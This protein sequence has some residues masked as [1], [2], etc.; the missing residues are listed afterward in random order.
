MIQ[1]KINTKALYDAYD[2]C[3]VAMMEQVNQLTDSQLNSIPFHGSW[4]AGQVMEH[5]T[6]SNTGIAKALN[7]EGMAVGRNADA[8]EP[9]LREMFLDFSVK[10]QSPDFILPV[11]A[12]YEPKQVEEDFQNSLSLLK[13]VGDHA[14]LEEAIKHPAFGEI[15]KL[16]LLCFVKFHLQRHLLQLKKI[17][18]AL[19]CS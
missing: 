3:A 2:E 1:E 15:T 10:F 17:V 19:R 13:K 7:I 16:E 11:R 4:S 9:E 18:L 12:H 8:R 14:N 6:K 5:V